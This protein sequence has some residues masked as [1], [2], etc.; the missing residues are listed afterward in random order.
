MFISDVQQQQQQKQEE[1]KFR[2][3]EVKKFSKV[4]VPCLN[5]SGIYS[6]FYII[7]DIFAQ[8]FGR[9]LVAKM[10]LRIGIWNVS[11]FLSVW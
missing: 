1:I 8:K 3:I 5:V 2:S 11:G 6:E 4:L 10:V 7:I 9:R